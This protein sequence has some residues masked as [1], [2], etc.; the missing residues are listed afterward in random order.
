MAPKL[1]YQALYAKWVKYR[2]LLCVWVGC[3]EE[4]AHTWTI[5]KTRCLDPDH[6]PFWT[7]I[8]SFVYLTI[9]IIIVLVLGFVIMLSLQDG[10][11]NALFSILVICCKWL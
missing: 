10:D 3:W 6:T 5:H 11:S 2:F 7:T 9:I 8:K 1:A 4:Q